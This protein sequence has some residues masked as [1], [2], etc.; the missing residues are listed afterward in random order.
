MRRARARSLM[1]TRMIWAAPLFPA[2][3]VSNSMFQTPPIL[4]TGL[5]SPD[6]W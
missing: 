3:E 2:H 6:E 4:A 1:K 5:G